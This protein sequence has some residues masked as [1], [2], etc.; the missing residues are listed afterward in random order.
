MDRGLGWQAAG[1]CEG[2]QA[3]ARELLRRD[4][5]PNVAAFCALG[6]E[7]SDQVD[8]LLLRPVDVLTAMQERAE[9]LAAVAS[10]VVRD[11]GVG[12]QHSF[13]PLGSAAS[14]VPEFGEMFEVT[15]EVAFVPG[16]QDR[17]DVWEVLV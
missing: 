6:Q 13:E 11:Q 3:V 9:F 15:D 2:V 7:V 5:I 12:L 8:E 10:T 17:F 1:C 16:E 14:L 4:I